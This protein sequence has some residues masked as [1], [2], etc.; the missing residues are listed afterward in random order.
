MRNTIAKFALAAALPL[1]MLAGTAAADETKD[2][3]VAMC[4]AGGDSAE[5]CACQVDAIVANVDPRAVAVLVASAEA[6]KAA[7]PEAKQK[8]ID[9]A[10]AAAGITQAEFQSLMEAGATKAGPAMEACMA[11]A[12][13]A[14]TP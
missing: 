7:T 10:L 5:S 9:D 8:I 1:F 14:P 3:L 12:A 13:P 2:K 4:V 6:E 11:P